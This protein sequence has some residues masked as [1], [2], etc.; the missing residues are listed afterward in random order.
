ML[1]TLA[2]LMV[3]C[4][5]LWQVSVFRSE[6][7]IFF[8]NKSIFQIISSYLEEESGEYFAPNFFNECCAKGLALRG[9]GFA[10]FV[11]RDYDA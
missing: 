4:H 2:E 7:V 10:T 9:F 5:C 3:I 11:M 8:G 6:T 1:C